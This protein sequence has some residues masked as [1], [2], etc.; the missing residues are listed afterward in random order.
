MFGTRLSRIGV[1]LLLVGGLGL[2]GTSASAAD[3]K[4]MNDQMLQQ[5]VLRQQFPAT[6]G[7]WTQ[8]LYRTDTTEV[9]AVCYSGTGEQLTLPK[10]LNMGEVGYQIDQNTDASVTI[11]QYADQ[12]SADAAL[13]ALRA[14]SCPGNAKIKAESGS[15]VAAQQSGDFTNDATNGQGVGLTYL[16]GGKRAFVQTTTTVVGLA[17]VQ[18]QVRTFVQKKL[19]AAQ[20]GAYAEKIESVDKKWHKRVLGSYKSFGIDGIAR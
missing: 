20:T 1:A 5:T 14:I 6:L 19:T 10:P 13:K 9:P 15:L 16:D 2:T 3:L 18:T 4:P 8:Y 11:Y 12:A 17:A 7:A